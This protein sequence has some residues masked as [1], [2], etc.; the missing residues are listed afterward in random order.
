[1][2]RSF[3]KYPLEPMKPFKF[4]VC[5]L[6]TT[7]ASFAAAQDPYM[8]A[9]EQLRAVN[10][11]IS[12]VM[13]WPE[14][15]QGEWVE[16]TNDSNIAVDIAGWRLRDG[17][18]IDFAISEDAFVIPPKSSVVVMLDGTGQKPT[19]FTRNRATAHS[20]K[21]VSGDVLK[22][23]GGQLALYCNVGNRH[24]REIVKGFVAWGRSP[25]RVLDDAMRDGVWSAW[26]TEPNAVVLGTRPEIYW[27]RYR[28]QV[29][30]FC[31]P[32]APSR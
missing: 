25:G 28:H 2:A 24:E 5:L 18:A 4:G 23:R 7:L 13:Y 3:E 20:P 10:V 17:S 15:G 14:A 1:M 21:G 11:V 29:G 32:G 16:L 22:D 27:S 8:A 19:A 30:R 6:T 31:R 9:L 26:R 12:E